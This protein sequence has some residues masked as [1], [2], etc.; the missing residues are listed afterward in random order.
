MPRWFFL[1]FGH[2][3][4]GLGILG[5]FLP[6]LP[7]T[8]FLILAAA[9]YRRGSARLSAWLEQHPRLGPPLRDWE[10]GGVIRVRIKR[11]AVPV[12]W[13]GM[14]YSIYIV[15]LLTVQILLVCIG[16]AVTLFIVTRPSRSDSNPTA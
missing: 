13:L 11:I 14:T 15:P 2:C 6:L 10:Q 12:V 3:C 16:V 8:P 1:L 9:C 4:V 5:S 7:T